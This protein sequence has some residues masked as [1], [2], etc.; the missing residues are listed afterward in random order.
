MLDAEAWSIDDDAWSTG[1]S[2]ASA[3]GSWPTCGG[4]NGDTASA[5]HALAFAV[6]RAADANPWAAVPGITPRETG[7]HA[8]AAVGSA[9]DLALAEPT[10]ITELVHGG[11]FPVSPSWRKSPSTSLPGLRRPVGLSRPPG[12][13]AGAGD[14]R[15]AE[16][17]QTATRAAIMANAEP[18]PERGRFL[19]LPRPRRGA[20]CPV[21][22]RVSTPA[23]TI[24]Q[25]KLNHR[26]RRSRRPPLSAATR[27]ATVGADSTAYRS[28]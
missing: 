12:R 26:R 13:R 14:Q 20:S 5:A 11:R 25:L 8:D 17:E 18:L 19:Y 1:W 16:D 6:W 4:T 9:G 2:A 28:A 23:L 24:R 7:S 22:S 15:A 10:R 27:A 3:T 21:G